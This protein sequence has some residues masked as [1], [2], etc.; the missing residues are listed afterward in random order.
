MVERS[1]AKSGAFKARGKASRQKIYI[2]HFDAK[3]R[4]A[5][6]TLFCSTLFKPYSNAQQ[7]CH[8]TFSG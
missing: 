8:L 6:F 7:I 2:W 5:L 4:F 3:L 1:E